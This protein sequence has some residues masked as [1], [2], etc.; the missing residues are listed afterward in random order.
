LK[1]E[2]NQQPNKK[3]STLPALDTRTLNSNGTKTK[4]TPFPEDEA[5]NVNK[6]I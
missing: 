3:D 1:I 4:F 6:N 2:T 5:I